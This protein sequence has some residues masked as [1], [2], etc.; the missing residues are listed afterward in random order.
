VD[1]HNLSTREVFVGPFDPLGRPCSAPGDSVYLVLFFGDYATTAMGSALQPATSW[2][3][4]EQVWKRLTGNHCTGSPVRKSRK[5]CDVDVPGDEGQY[6][7]NDEFLLFLLCSFR[8]ES[9][10]ICHPITLSWRQYLLDLP[11]S[12]ILEMVR[13]AEIW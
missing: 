10:I 4:T 11:Y 12:A 3:T 5:P 1:R 6:K 8:R 13:C 2:Q 7:D 9:L